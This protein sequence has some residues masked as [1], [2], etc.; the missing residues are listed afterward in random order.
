MSKPDFVI[1]KEQRTEAARALPTFVVQQV[2]GKLIK[3]GFVLLPSDTCYTLGTLAVDESSRNNVNTI[4]GRK[5][6]EPISLA[7]GSYL[8]VQQFVEMDITTELLL[9]RFTPGPITIVC[10]AKETI[11]KEFLVRTLASKD[12]T[13]GVRIPDCYIERD[14]AASTNYPLM[15]VAVRDLNTEEAVVDFTQALEIVSLGIERLGG[16]GWAAIEEDSNFFF[17]TH[18]TV[19]R[20]GGVGKVELLRKGDT[21]FE[22]ILATVNSSSSI[23]GLTMED[24]G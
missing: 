2:R 18:S 23:S 3:R 10:R 21:P 13:V 12:G 8:Q 24:W 19:V 17:A 22:R 15:S 20:V 6:D 5:E 16:A 7:F 9:E 1:K 14:I 4:L 11:S